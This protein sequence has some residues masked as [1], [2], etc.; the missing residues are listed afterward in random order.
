MLKIVYSER[1]PLKNTIR[2]WVFYSNGNYKSVLISVYISIHGYYTTCTIQSSG[3]HWSE[4]LLDALNSY[5]SKVC[6]LQ[7]N[8]NNNKC[9]LVKIYISFK[10]LVERLKRG[11]P[12]KPP[13]SEANGLFLTGSGLEIVVFDII[14]K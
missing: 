5:F 3:M 2:C 14:W 1:T 9:T 13:V 12:L 7:Y 10:I 6:K 8:N 4:K 11:F